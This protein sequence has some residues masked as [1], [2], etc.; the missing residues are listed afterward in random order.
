M[1]RFGL[2]KEKEVSIFLGLVV[3]RE[4]AFLNIGGFSYTAG[5][6]VL[7]R[8]I[9]SSAN[10]HRLGFEDKPLQVPYGSE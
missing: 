7:L 8:H 3:V 6:F 10:Q 2:Q 9:I 5:N 1:A 4:E